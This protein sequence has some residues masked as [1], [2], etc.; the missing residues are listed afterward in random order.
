[1]KIKLPP[2]LL[3]FL[4]KRRSFQQLADALL[5]SRAIQIFFLA[6]QPEA[7]LSE[8]V[9]GHHCSGRAQIAHAQCGG[10][11]RI[12]GQDEGFISFAPVLNNSNVDG[13][14]SGDVELIS[15]HDELN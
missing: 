6:V 3:I 13:R 12:E 4:G 5:H 14:L 8:F 11:G 2:A 1:M 7:I 10:Q 9:A 15:L